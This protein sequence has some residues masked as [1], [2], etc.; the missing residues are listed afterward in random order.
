MSWPENPSRRRFPPRKNPENTENVMAE[1]GDWILKIISGPHQGVEEVLRAGRIVVGTAPE[2]DIVLHDVL[3][4]AQHLAFTLANGAV[5]VETL[6]GRVYCQGKRVTAS[7]AVQPFN[8]ITAGTTQLVLGPVD[9][10]WPLLSAADAPELEKDSPPPPA[11]PDAAAEGTTANP[12]APVAAAP[13]SDKNTKPTA[14]QRRRAWWLVGLGGLI[15]V[16]WAGLW[17][18]W[19]PTPEP[20]AILGPKARAEKVIKG[21]PDA[22][23]IKL[24]ERGDRLVVSGYVDSDLT[25]HDLTAALRQDAPEATLRLWSTPRVAE[26]TR[27]FLADRKLT[28]TL[29]PGE[30][31]ELTIRGTVPTSLEWVRARQMLLAEVPGLVRI[32][33]EVTVAPVPRP[34]KARPEVA[35]VVPSA[36]GLTIVSLQ[37]L[38]D[39]QGWIRLGNGAVLFRGAR[40]ADKTLLTGVRDGQATFDQAGRGFTASPGDDLAILLQPAKSAANEKSLPQTGEKTVPA[41]PTR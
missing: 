36:D 24:E 27:A 29:S 41:A 6:E 10:R 7:A 9:A 37:A 25:H 2:C 3:V 33:D 11:A 32:I 38:T 34:N 21:F 40:L 18:V 20:V 1:T 15:L 14:D 4:A 5:T 31:G 8:F 17:F 12:D 39:G 28:L 26:T 23:H 19:R 16:V 22:Q 35:P 13:E 30:N